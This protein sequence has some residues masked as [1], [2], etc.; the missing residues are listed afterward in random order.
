[1]R[2]IRCPRSGSATRRRATTPARC[3]PCCLPNPA[4][5]LGCGH[6][7][8][9][10]TDLLG[11]GP[12]PEDVNGHHLGPLLLGSLD[13]VWSRIREQLSG[14]TEGEYLWEPAPGGWSV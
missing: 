4:A 9:T 11:S 1:M 6:Y 7:W 2:P 13:Y 14:L 8:R 12:M 10:D 3:P 5:Q